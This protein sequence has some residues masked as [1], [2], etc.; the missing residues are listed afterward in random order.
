[1]SDLEKA[2]VGRMTHQETDYDE[3]VTA[4]TYKRYLFDYFG[5]WKFLFLSNLSIITFT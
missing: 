2:S 4:Q 5:G 1:M 3:R